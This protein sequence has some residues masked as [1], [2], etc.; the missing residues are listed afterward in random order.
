[1]VWARFIEL[2]TYGLNIETLS[3]SLLKF[4]PPSGKSSASEL[5][6]EF[7]IAISIRASDSKD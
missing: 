2:A 1:M 7:L 6:A 3:D 4:L 5:E